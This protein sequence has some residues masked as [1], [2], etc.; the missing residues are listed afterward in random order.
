MS[1]V[2]HV[3]DDLLFQNPDIVNSIR[4]GGAHTTVYM[5]AGDAGR[6]TA[7][8]E[9]REAGAKA[10]YAYMAGHDDWIDET[11]VLS[12]GEREFSIQTS[13]L[14]SQPDVRLYFLRLPDGNPG[15]GGYGVNDYESVEKLWNGSM[16]TITTKDG[17]NTYTSDDLSGLLLWLMES[18]QPDAIP[19]AD[20]NS[21]HVGSDHSDHFHTAQFAY[22][23][24]QYYKTDHDLYSYVEYATANMGANLEGDDALSTREAFYEYV[25]DSGDI[26]QTFDA[27]G[28]PVL[29]GSYEAWPDR[30]YHDE[31]TGQ[32][33]GSELWLAELGNSMGGW[34][35]ERH[36]RTT[37]DIDGDGMA[38][39]VGFGDRGVYTAHSNGEAFEQVKLAF[40]D[41]T[42]SAGVWLVGEHERVVADVN[43]DG[44]EDAA[45]FGGEDTV[46]AIS[47]GDGTF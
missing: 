21:E 41:L 45:G 32:P 2:A 8:M 36:I 15:G 7:Y 4:A 19:L 27:N 23:A 18:H 29:S 14:G 26:T 13:Y 24:Q 16:D 43:G 30:H 39:I 34:R 3:D 10:A 35:N 17:V 44:L 12:D 46:V 40:S 11:I 38:E 6:D 1:I 28:D 22:G 37:G 25:R 31:E 5:T 47:R 42:Y 9:A 20:L 33:A